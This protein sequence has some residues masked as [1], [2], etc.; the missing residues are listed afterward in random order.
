MVLVNTTLEVAQKRNQL[1]DRILPPEL[2][3]R[4]WTDVQK[5]IGSFQA[6]FKNNFV[7]VDNSKHLD[8]KQAEKKFVPLVSK[9]VRKFANSPIKNKIALRW[10]AKQK[11]LRRK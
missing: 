10:V 6:L 1:R 4:S 3:K 7:V 11:L 8:D 9:V 5:N 2:L